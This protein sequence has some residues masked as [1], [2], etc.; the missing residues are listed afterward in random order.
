MRA[1]KT[2]IL[3]AALSGMTQLAQADPLDIHVGWVTM[4]AS[5]VPLSLDKKELLPHYGKSYTITPIRMAST[6]AMITAL[7]T[8][9]V[10]VGTL[11]YSSL[12]SAILNAKMSDMRIIMDVNQ[13][14][15]DN[16]WSG[17]FMVLR[18]GPVK[19]VEDLKGKVIASL[20]YG[21]A[22]DVAIRAMLRKHG[23]DDKKDVTFVEA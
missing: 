9:D 10:N 15:V 2:I 5:S 21:S 6:A 19:K 17:H 16:G 23:L 13:D 11:A 22:V 3:A 1:F 18:D 4:Y 14:G 8:G 7:A 20:T 12:A